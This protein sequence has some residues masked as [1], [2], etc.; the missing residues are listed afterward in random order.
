MSYKICT[1]T[2]R[3]TPSRIK[4]FYFSQLYFKARI[5]VTVTTVGRIRVLVKI[6]TVFSKKVPWFLRYPFPEIINFFWGGGIFVFELLSVT[7]IYAKW[8]RIF[9]FLPLFFSFLF[10]ETVCGTYF[11]QWTLRGVGGRSRFWRKVVDDRIIIFQLKFTFFSW[12]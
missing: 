9:Y 8:G 11:S 2:I 4:T 3:F 12:S 7:R 10:Q 6:C 1:F 5:N